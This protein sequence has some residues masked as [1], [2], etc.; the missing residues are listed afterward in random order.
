M[1]WRLCYRQTKS[2]IDVKL[3]EY[4]A[5]SYMFEPMSVLLDWCKKIKK[6]KEKFLSVFP[7]C[8]W[9]AREVIPGHT[10]KF[11]STHGRTNG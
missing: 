4:D 3:S 8:W 7:F 11:E 5:K 1:I 2:I 9:H 10:H 6:D